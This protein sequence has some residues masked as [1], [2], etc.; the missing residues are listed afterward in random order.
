MGWQETRIHKRGYDYNELKEMLTEK[1]LGVLYAAY[2]QCEGKVTLQELGT[3][4]TA[5]YYL[6]ASA[7][8]SY[9]LAPTCERHGAEWL[10]PATPIPGL[11]LTGQD[12]V[13]GGITGAMV[14]GFFTAVTVCRSVLWSQRDI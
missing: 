2:P 5:E 3:P 12:V 4:L 7:G 1:L 6:G 8:A 10:T 14:A 9:G 11:Y 13:S